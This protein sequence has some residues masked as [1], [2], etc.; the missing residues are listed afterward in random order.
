MRTEIKNITRALSLV[1]LVVLVGACSDDDDAKQAAAPYANFL[2]TEVTVAQNKGEVITMIEWGGTQWSIE[3][4][5]TADSFITAVS[6]TQGGNEAQAQAYERI[7]IAYDENT[8]EDARS[9]NLILTNRATGETSV[10]TVTQ[11]TEHMPLSATLHPGTRYQYVEGFGGMYNPVIWI[12]KMTMDEVRLVCG[13]DGLGYNILRLMIYPDKADWD[14]DIEAALYAQSQGVVLFA[15]P[16]EWRNGAGAS[17]QAFADPEDYEAYA[18]YLIEYYDYMKAAGVDIYALS[19]QNEPDI[20][21][22]R[23]EE[24][25]DFVKQCGARIRAT[26]VKL[27]ATEACGFQPEYTDAILNDPMAFEQTDIVAGHLYQ[28]FTD[29]D[30]GY[31][32]ARYEYV[33]GLYAR[34]APKGNS[35]WMTEKYFD[36]QGDTLEAIWLYQLHNF[37]KELH[38]SMDGG[39]EA[40]VYWT[41]RRASGWCGLIGEPNSALSIDDR[42]VA[43]D[44]YIL[45]HYAHYAKYLNR[46]SVDCENENVLI[47]AYVDATG[48]ELTAVILNLDDEDYKVTF[49]TPAGTTARSASAVETSETRSMEATYAGI[50]EG[51]AFVT[52]SPNSIVSVRIQLD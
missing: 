48:K 32:R 3:P 44:G 9:Q 22:R 45:S 41:L 25:R 34:L 39:C 47:T 21:N 38:L 30:N 1:L 50:N 24:V 51:K 11:R 13:P 28:G 12:Q 37:G 27:M 49:D 8:T 14:T 26:G 29:L 33:C 46:I 15:S 16:W 17:D 20:A 36:D 7:T 2:R 43:K 10:M 23:P 19:V 40:Y 6:L 35:W 4:E 31:V 52:L 18:D 5:T 42:G